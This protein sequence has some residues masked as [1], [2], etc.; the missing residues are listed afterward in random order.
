MQVTRLL[1]NLIWSNPVGS[2]S[3]ES[4][5]GLGDLNLMKQPSNT[6]TSVLHWERV[7]KVFSENSLFLARHTYFSTTFYL[8]L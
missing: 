6:Q 7:N 8:L 2:S 3:A 4:G 1:P 5:N